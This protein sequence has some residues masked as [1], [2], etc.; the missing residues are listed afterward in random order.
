[1]RRRSAFVVGVVVV[2][3]AATHVGST[4][5]QVPGSAGDNAGLSLGSLSVREDFE[6]EARGP[7][8]SVYAEDPNRCW[9]TESNHRLELRATAE[10]DR[11]YAGYLLSGWRLDP[12]SD[13]AVKVD[14]YYGPVTDAGGWLGL[15]LTPTTGTPRT[16][17]VGVGIGCAN[18]GSH[19]YYE[20]RNEAS[21]KSGYSER[22]TDSVT[23]YLSYDASLDEL[24]LSDGGYGLENAWTTFPGLVQGH[25]GGKPLFVLLGGGSAQLTLGAGQV[26]ADNLLVRSGAEAQASLQEVYRFWAPGS[27]RHFYTISKLEKE[28]VLTLYP[29]VWIYEGAVYRAFPDGSNPD[30]RAVHRFWCE[31]LASHFYTIKERERDKLINEYPDFWTY[32]GIAF[33]A[34]PEG[35]QP[36]WTDAVHRFWSESKGTHFYTIDE[37]EKDRLRSKH[38]DVWTYEGIAW[39]AVK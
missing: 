29:Q 38:A 23:V 14:L 33:Y 1:M 27:E 5:G 25:W 36:G 12:A 17:Y 20:F 13:F 30:C 24:Y 26:F 37:A 11:I 10:A 9:V 32:E 3:T 7:L 18:R 15:G 4:R 34:W 8:W 19:Y 6:D 16:Q 2:A 22:E 21:I 31:T 35:Q 39:Y 28:K